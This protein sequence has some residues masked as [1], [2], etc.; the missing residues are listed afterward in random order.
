METTTTQAQDLTNELDA[1]LAKLHAVIESGEEQ[2]NL[3]MVKSDLKAH[4]R[5]IM[6]VLD[7]LDDRDE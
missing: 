2:D 7:M 3:S 1:I 6:D 5:T 4:V